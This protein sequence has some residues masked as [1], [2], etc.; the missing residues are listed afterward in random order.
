MGYTDIE[1]CK[2]G[3]DNTVERLFIVGDT[4]TAK[5]GSGYEGKQT[6]TVSGYTCLPWNFESMYP[7]TGSVAHR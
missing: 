5:L 2:D 6:T 1:A 7:N 3:A 4:L